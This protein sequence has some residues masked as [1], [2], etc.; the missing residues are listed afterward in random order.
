MYLLI[1][2]G[3]ST[4]T[5]EPCGGDHDMRQ[6]KLLKHASAIV[7]DEKNKDHVNTGITVRLN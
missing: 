6:S 7:H 5:S 3:T 4:S 2:A 1:F